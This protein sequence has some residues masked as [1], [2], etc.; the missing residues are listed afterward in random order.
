MAELGGRRRE[1]HLGLSEAG[2]SGAEFRSG[3]VRSAGCTGHRGMSQA[4]EGIWGVPNLRELRAMA[5]EFPVVQI[6][7]TLLQAG[8]LTVDEVRSMRGLGSIAPA[9]TQ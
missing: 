6:Q 9:V 1:A 5:V 8:V 4:A 3:D 2:L 7:T